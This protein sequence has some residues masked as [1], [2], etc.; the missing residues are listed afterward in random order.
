MRIGPGPTGSA[1]VATAITAI[2]AIAPI[3]GITVRFRTAPPLS[4]RFYDRRRALVRPY[5]TWRSAEILYR[6]LL[7]SGSLAVARR[8][9]GVDQPVLDGLLGGHEAGA[10]GFAQHLVDVLAGMARDDLRHSPGHVEDL[11]GG[12]LDVRGRA[13]EA[14][15]ALVDHDLRVRQRV[16]LAGR[17]AAEDHRP[18]AHPHAET[19]RRH[20]R[21]DVLHGVIDRHPGIRRPAWRVHVEEDVAAGILRVEMEQLGRDQVR[22]LVVHLLAQEHDSLAQQARVDVEGALPAP[23]LLDDHRNNGAHDHGN[24]L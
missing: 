3:A 6:Y 8:H 15:G 5:P 13:A 16:A 20:I 9:H 19:D 7:L 12:D 14:A 4:S 21:L 10:A 11:A 2:T 17:A 22:D 23:V 18:G 1:G 24:L